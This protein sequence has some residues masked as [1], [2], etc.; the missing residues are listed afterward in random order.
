MDVDDL[1]RS[2]QGRDAEPLTIGELALRLTVRDAARLAA[3]E[4]LYPARDLD[5]IE[6]EGEQ[7]AHERVAAAGRV[8]VLERRETGSVVDR[9]PQ[10]E[11]ADCQRLRVAPLPAQDQVVDV[12]RN[13]PRSA[14][15][16]RFPGRLYAQDRVAPAAGSSDPIVTLSR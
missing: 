14:L 11:L 13:P 9:Q 16:R 5:R 4:D 15:W 1:I 10:R 2:W 3:L 7:I 6:G 12:H 8:Q